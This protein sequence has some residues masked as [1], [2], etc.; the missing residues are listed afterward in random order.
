MSYPVMTK[1]INY[2]INGEKLLAKAQVFWDESQECTFLY[3]FSTFYDG[4]WHEVYYDERA[5]RLVVP[6]YKVSENEI[7]DREY[8]K[9][10]VD[11]LWDE[12][13]AA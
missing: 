11:I 8:L 9:K 2:G 3:R 5:S 4:R 6:D 13:A 10:I 12:F 1:T 7:F